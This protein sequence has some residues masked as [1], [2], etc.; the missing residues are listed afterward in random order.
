MLKDK[1]KKVSGM[2]SRSKRSGKYNKR[3]GFDDSCDHV[4]VALL[5]TCQYLPIIIFLGAIV[6]GV[7]A[8]VISTNMSKKPFLSEEAPQIVGKDKWVVLS[9]FADEDCTQAVKLPYTKAVR[10][11]YCARM[12][13]R[14]TKYVLDPQ[15]NSLVLE[16]YEGEDCIANQEPSRTTSNFTRCQRDGNSSYFVKS[17]QTLD[18][19]NLD[20]KNPTSKEFPKLLLYPEIQFLEPEVEE[21]ADLQ[22]KRRTKDQSMTAG[23]CFVQVMDEVNTGYMLTD[24]S[25]IRESKYQQH[26]NNNC[27][28]F[29]GKWAWIWVYDS[30]APSYENGFYSTWAEEYFWGAAILV[31]VL[32]ALNV[33]QE[34]YLMVTD[35][36]YEWGW[37]SAPSST[38]DGATASQ[39]ALAKSVITPQ[40]RKK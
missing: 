12:Y 4:L 2:K 6:A 31:F 3:K 29:E 9:T 14:S 36:E 25:I 15:T 18:S 21:K 19:V 24:N 30:T 26:A 17:L 1:Q 16:E 5:R 40:K 11:N 38:K 34:I 7:V 10:L 8:L 33:L 39:K 13:T 37:A 28:K 22:G 23:K 32:I 20:P 35:E 27:F